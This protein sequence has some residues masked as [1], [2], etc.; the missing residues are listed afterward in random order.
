[1]PPTQTSVHDAMQSLRV[2]SQEARSKTWG[3]GK[4]LA[5]RT[6][7]DVLIPE[8]PFARQ[9][10]DNTCGQAAM[11]MLL[12]Y[13]DVDVDYDQIAREGNP[14]N[15]ATSRQAIQIYLEGKGLQVRHLNGSLESLLGE[16][17]QARPV[18]LLLDFGG[19][20]H[21]HYVVAVGYNARQGRILIHDSN[22][23]PYKQMSL[24]EFLQRWQNLPAVTLPLIGGPEYERLMF[25]VS[26]GDAS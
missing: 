9:G 12:H 21:M 7:G 15:V 4:S 10:R 20:D 16:L 25:A 6:D 14:L 24:S 2:L 8:V 22:K 1:M 26:P 18:L 5:V 3:N 11:A 23:E 13:W 19:I 17:H